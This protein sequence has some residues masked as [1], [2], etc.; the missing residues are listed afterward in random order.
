MYRVLIHHTWLLSNTALTPTKASTRQGL[1]KSRWNH[2]SEMKWNLHF[3][4][5]SWASKSSSLLV[6]AVVAVLVPLLS[7]FE[8]VVVVTVVESQDPQEASTTVKHHKQTTMAVSFIL[9]NNWNDKK[10]LRTTTPNTV[11]KQMSYTF[12][13]TAL[14]HP[15]HRL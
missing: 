12:A 8:V 15:S 5:I 9:V 13:A 11:D 3:I 10:Q 2:P 1:G 14:Y 7:Q 4:E 6:L